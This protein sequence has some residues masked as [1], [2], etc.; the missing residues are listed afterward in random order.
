[1]GSR[2]NTTSINTVV[3]D[4][5]Q[6]K[7]QIVHKFTII[8]WVLGT[9]AYQQS[10]RLSWFPVFKI[11]SF[12]RGNRKL[13]N[14]CRTMVLMQHAQCCYW[15][16]ATTSAN[17]C[18]ARVSPWQSI[19]RNIQVDQDRLTCPPG[20]ADI[21]CPTVTFLHPIY[22]TGSIIQTA[23]W[24]RSFLRSKQAFW[25]AFHPPPCNFFSSLL[26]SGMRTEVE[27][28]YSNRLPHQLLNKLF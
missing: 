24:S 17:P 13:M 27:W 26:S 22:T 20:V 16:T 4:P 8:F 6:F 12:N 25:Q 10:Y 28:E 14:K 15:R 18:R 21:I 9:P 7:P 23:G 3:W 1:M 2:Y 5:V 19:N 11:H